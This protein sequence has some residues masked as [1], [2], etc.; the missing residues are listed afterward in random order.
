MFAPVAFASG[1]RTLSQQGC[2][3][4]LEIGP[5][6]VLVG[7]ARRCLSTDADS[8]WIPSLRPGQD[9]WRTL[10]D[11]LSALYLKGV[12]VNWVGFDRDYPR[13]RLALPT[14]PFERQRYWLP[15]VPNGRN[16]SRAAGSQPR[17]ERQHDLL[18]RRLASPLKETLFEAHLGPRQPPYLQDHRILGTTVL[19]LTGFLEMALAA[20]SQVFGREP[21]H[22]EAVIAEEWLLLPEDHD[23]TVQVI[24]TPQGSDQASFQVFRQIANDGERDAWR[25]HARGTMRKGAPAIEPFDLASALARCPQGLEIGACYQEMRDSGLEYGPAFRGLIAMNRG[26]DEAVGQIQLPESLLSGAEAYHFHPAM[27]DTCI[28]PIGKALPDLGSNSTWIPVA[29]ERLTVLGSP[30]HRVWCHARARPEDPA[31]R[32]RRVCDLVI[33]NDACRPV[34][35]LAGLQLQRVERDVLRRST[36]TKKGDW[37]YHLDWQPRPVTGGEWA[38]GDSQGSWLIFADAGGI[39]VE[40]ARL[41]EARGETCFVAFAAHSELAPAVRCHAIDPADPAAY[42]WLLREGRSEGAP[43]WRGVVYLWALEDALDEPATAES[44]QTGLSAKV[45]PA[46]YLCQAASRYPRPPKLWLVTRGTQQAH[47][48]SPVGSLEGAP[49]WG[50]T[51]VVALEHPELRCTCLDLSPVEH[52]DEAGTLYGELGAGDG[53][54]QIAFRDDVR[55]VARLARGLGEEKAS[56]LSAPEGEAFQLQTSPGG[57]LENLVLRPLNRREPRPGEV[58]IRVQATGQNFRD[59]LCALGMYPGEMPPLGGECAG[60]VVRVGEGVHSFRPGDEV[61]AIA[62]GSFASHVTVDTRMVVA[63][64]PMLTPDEAATVPIAFLTA[65]YGLHVLGGLRPGERVDPCG[66]RR[67]RDGGGPARPAG[68]RPCLC[69]RESIQVGGR[70]R[71][72]CRARHELAHP[73]FRQRSH[74][75]NGRTGRGPGSQLPGR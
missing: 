75:S 68:P 74:A 44:L 55:L 62:P 53:E 30:P 25:V 21:C 63:R 66:R 69:H 1:V 52:H 46:P 49:L 16:S 10:L 34:A 59:V 22:L 3:N 7:L 50:L 48:G 15:P 72:G 38:H 11:G 27:L 51:R 23:Q 45:R 18:G 39:G 36:Q 14:Y 71:L 8:V 17:G 20:A 70:Q 24:V 73:G 6:P 41:L 29:L 64:P 37:L 28:H 54:D 47:A 19:P 4:W 35:Q 26:T 57:V 67:C 31:R 33:V 61:I 43:P 65:W 2:Q 40:L 42:A 13:R 32:N 56:G 5:A 12:D 9:N 58:E 60:Q